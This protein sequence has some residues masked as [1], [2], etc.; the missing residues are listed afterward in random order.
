MTKDREL[1][2]IFFAEH[3]KL[4]AHQRQQAT[5]N[6]GNTVEMPRSTCTTQGSLQAAW[7]S[8]PKN[9]LHTLGIDLS[10]IRTP[11]R[12]S[13][14]FSCHTTIC[15]EIAGIS[16]EVFARTELQWV[17]VN[18][19]QHRTGFFGQI[20]GVGD[21]GGVPGVEPSH[22][23]HEVHRMLLLRTPLAQGRR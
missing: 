6:R 1:L 17:D 12:I 14:S 23:W 3:Q 19:G 15:F 18:A 20:T 8:D 21:Q 9:L 11:D 16:G 22:R 2:P 10:V 13:A 5:H 4:W 7:N